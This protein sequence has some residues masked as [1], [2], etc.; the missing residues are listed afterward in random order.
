MRKVCWAV[1]IVVV[2]TGW[3]QGLGAAP[4][5]FTADV[6]PN[7][8]ILILPVARVSPDGAG[9]RVVFELQNTG[10]EL[11]ERPEIELR[12]IGPDGK[13][14]GFVGF[15]L[16]FSVAPGEKVR[17]FLH[18]GSLSAQSEDTVLLRPTRPTAAELLEA[19]AGV[20]KSYRQWHV[21][22]EFSGPQCDTLCSAKDDECES[23]CPCGVR[24][25]TCNCGTNGGYSYSCEC[26]KNC[27]F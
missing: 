1:A 6:D 16:D 14:R 15:K 18:T 13:L 9:V 11:L 17:S 25:F 4:E 23:R 2:S 24:S 26:M 8:Q 20:D 5:T 7:G 19:P 10:R 22:P 21:K 27:P 12:V 3:V